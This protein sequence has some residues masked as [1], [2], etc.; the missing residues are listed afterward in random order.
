MPSYDATTKHL[1]ESA[2]LDWVA[3][4]GFPEVKSAHMV[5]TDLSTVTAVAD[6]V[7]LVD[8]SPTW[9]IHIEF[10]SSYDSVMGLRLC[11]YNVLLVEYQHRIPVLSV[12]VLLS[13][14]ADGSGISGVLRRCC[15][16][17]RVMM[18]FGIRSFG[19]GNFPWKACLQAG[20]E[21]CLS[22]R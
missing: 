12:L 11:R 22:H 19:C 16:M 9:M 8:E 4:A 10:Q 13:P 1:V 7:I 20:W 18:N 14:D 6:K 5:D 21:H 3:L 15:R 2:P 17:K